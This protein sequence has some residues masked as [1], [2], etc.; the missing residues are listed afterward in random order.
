MG[1]FG[2]I[3]LI[4]NIPFILL[5]VFLSKE[6]RIKR[7]IKKTK[8]KPINKIK[9][10]QY[11]KVQGQASIAKKYIFSPLQQEKCIGFH[12]NIGRQRSD[13]FED[14]YINEEVCQDFYITHGQD[15]ILVLG[16]NCTMNIKMKSVG[17]S[18]LFN[19]ANHNL[20]TFLKR[21]RTS[22]TSF[23]F[24]KSLQF[25]E[26]TIQASD[27]VTVVGEAVNVQTKSGE[28]ILALKATEKNSLYIQK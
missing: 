19:D 5:E 17:S 27:N 23:G 28:K 14:D 10:G 8:L 18:G 4:F 16:R 1:I 25:Q 12:V 7:K 11:I 22:S 20:E 21:H 6:Q 15:K 9:K 13:Y 2:I 3:E 26:G 24:N